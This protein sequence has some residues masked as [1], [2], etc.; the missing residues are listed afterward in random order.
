VKLPAGEDSS[1]GTLRRLRP[2]E[3]PGYR[4]VV[5]GRLSERLGAG[6]AGVTLERRPGQTILSGRGDRDVLEGLLE[7]LLDLNIELVSVD[8]HC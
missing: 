1:P 3:P 5:K 7:R 2:V 6:F 4:I 8:A